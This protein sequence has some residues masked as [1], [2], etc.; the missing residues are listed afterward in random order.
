MSF[1][2]NWYYL[3]IEFLCWLFVFVHLRH[4][5]YRGMHLLQI[6]QQSGYK[7]R[8]FRSWLARNWSLGVMSLAHFLMIALALLSWKFL[9]DVLTASAITLILVI[10]S[11]FWF[12][13]TARYRHHKKPLV[14]TARMKRLAAVTTLLALWIP[15]AGTAAAFTGP[16]AFPDIHGLVFSWMLLELLLPFWLMLAALLLSPVE[17]AI[18]KGFKKKAQARIA[19]MPHLKV[20]AITGSYGKTSTKFMIESVLR[21]RFR[22]C[23]TPGSFNTPM[24]ICKVINETLQ[25]T[26]QVF[27]VEMGARY[28]GNIDELCHIV[29]P[30]VAVITNVGLA[31]LETFGSVEAI[32]RTKG[33]MLRYL[34]P[35]GSAV[36][37]GDDERVRAMATELVPK[38]NAANVLMAGFSNDRNSVLARD[39]AYDANGCAFNLISTGQAGEPEQI[40]VQMPLLGSH[41]VHNA[42][43]AAAVGVILGMRLPT[44]R[45]G[46][47]Q[48]KPVEHRLELKNRN[49][50]L[51][52]D[53]AF[54]A[55]PVGARNAISVLDAFKSGRKYV[56]T[57]GMIELGD[58]ED[59]E[60]RAFGTWMAQHRLDGVWL[61][62]QRQTRAIREGLMEGGFPQERI[63]VTNSLFEANEQ[64]WPRLEPGDVVLYENDLPD[65]YSET[66]ASRA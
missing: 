64:L 50:V 43:F 16:A 54:N 36:L 45:A 37:N 57:P 44:I 25:P 19:S 30:D 49:G 32:A 7:P 51:I 29:Q 15:L 41:N 2:V 58:R 21:E 28:E 14:F 3:A 39:I 20:V 42:L 23:T 56:I 46:L 65:T 63:Y 12:G 31:H 26:D 66:T 4:A 61:V 13:S 10:F 11:L 9:V 60:N 6:F 47:E 62:G 1:D 22:V 18:Q 33:A 24:G 8:E 48:A 5:L 38:E 59:E 35:G 53:D 40:Q 17:R 52:I 34:K 27:I 55:N